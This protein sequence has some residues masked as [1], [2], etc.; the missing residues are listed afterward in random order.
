[1]ISS[2]VVSKN[3]SRG[4]IAYLLF[5]SP[6]QAALAAEGLQLAQARCAVSAVVCGGSLHHAVLAVVCCDTV[7]C[8]DV[9]AVV[10]CDVL[11]C[12]VP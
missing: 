8:H 12:A 4:D 7:L 2:R 11:H 10:Y 1:M 5:P 6:Q 9:P 3:D